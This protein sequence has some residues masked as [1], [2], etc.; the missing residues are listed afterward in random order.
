MAGSCRKQ[1]TPCVS[2]Q[3]IPAYLRN[4]TMNAEL[5][6]INKI[7]EGA[8]RH[9]AP[10]QFLTA[11]PQIVSRIGHNNKDV[12]QILMKI[13]ATVIQH[14]PRQALWPTVGVM[15]SN[16]PERKATCTVVLRRAQVKQVHGRADDRQVT[17]RISLP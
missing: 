12:A 4:N 1:G 16:R 13:M 14:Y 5:L 2:H 11:F 9:L 3:R 6:K 10:Y 8:R 15:Q 17:M 7:V